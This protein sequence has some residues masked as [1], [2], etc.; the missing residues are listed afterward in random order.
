LNTRRLE[1]IYKLRK[2]PDNPRVIKD[3]KFHKLVLSIKSFPEMLEK[4]PLVVNKDL[5]VL[6][7]NMR[8]RAA[9][10]AGLKEVWV[11]V[12]DWTEEK[13]REFII[14]D[15]S[16]FGEWDWDELAN[17]W[18]IDK[19]NEWALDMPPMFDEFKE[20]KEETKKCECC[21]K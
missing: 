15:N 14:K 8:L 5:I 18:D 9:Q 11:D 19:L 4:R 20:E 12:A 21:G 2:H 13:Q 1:K 10:A 7:G 3:V 6:G 16:S 17:T